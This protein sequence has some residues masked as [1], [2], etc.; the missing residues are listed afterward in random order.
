MPWRK[1]DVSDQ[2]LQ[3]VTLANAPGSCVAAL[4]REFGISRQTGHTWLKR[5]REGGGK[6]VLS[7]RSRRP[8]HSPRKTAAEMV[9]AI[10]KLRQD[11][12]DW[13]ARK[14][15]PVI[16]TSNPELA[17]T[18]ISATTVHRILEREQLI[19]PEDRR[20][21]A[22]QRFERSE[23]NELWQMD[24]KG[25]Q[26]FNKG[27]GPLS[28][29]DD[30]SRYLLALKHVGSTQLK[31]VQLSLQATF[32]MCGLP[33]FLLIDHGTPWYNSWNPWGWTELTVWILRQGIRIILSGVRH[34]QTQGKVER[35]HGALQRAIRKRKGAPDQQQWL[36]EFREEYNYRRPHEGIGM[37]PPA[38][39]WRPSPRPF[40]PH[41]REWEYAG[42]WEVH[43]LAGQGQLYWQGKRWDISRALRGQL[44]GLHR[45]GD[46]V[47]VHFCNVA[48]RE[49]DLRTAH[50]IVLPINPFRDLQW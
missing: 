26:G 13:G 44:V 31:G 28:I 19:A 6:A 41:P 10:K 32:E 14:L 30:F 40:Q 20:K 39:R 2:R 48:L 25:P 35:M 29:Q 33:E 50:N 3:F 43:R 15:L 36:D 1:V 34:P 17:G 47:L 11:K 4:C 45:T 49:I 7:E 46:R 27:T 8:H 42:D 38:T 16:L 21:P 24:F 23:P 37:V 18:S 5:Y 22:V 9:E 12:P